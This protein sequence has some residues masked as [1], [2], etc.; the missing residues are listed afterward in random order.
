MDSDHLEELKATLAK[1]PHTEQDHIAGFLLME[2]MKRN[3]LVMPVMHQRIDD[4]EPEN[5]KTWEKTKQSLGD[6]R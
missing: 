4:A 3:Q 5:W 1:L 6:N 2:R